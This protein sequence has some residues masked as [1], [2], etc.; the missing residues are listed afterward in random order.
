VFCYFEGK[1][2]AKTFD[3]LEHYVMDHATDHLPEKNLFEAFGMNWNYL[4]H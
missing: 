3:L 1:T 4:G 2:F